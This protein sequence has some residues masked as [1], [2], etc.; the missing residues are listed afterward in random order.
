MVTFL[1]KDK[2]MDPKKVAAVVTA[3]SRYIEPEAQ[4]ATQPPK[5]LRLWSLHGRQQLMQNR[6]LCQMR[7][8]KTGFLK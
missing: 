5:P 6:L 8:L 1:Y 7:I 4:W 3:V 2:G